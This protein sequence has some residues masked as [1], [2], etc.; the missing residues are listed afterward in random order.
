MDRR[1]LL[2]YGEAFLDLI[3]RPE[4]FDLVVDIMGP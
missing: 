2:N 4:V 1:D 3:D